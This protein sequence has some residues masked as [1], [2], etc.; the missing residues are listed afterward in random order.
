[1]IKAHTDY[2]KELTDTFFQPLLKDLSIENLGESQRGKTTDVLIRW[3]QENYMVEVEDEEKSSVELSLPKNVDTLE[4]GILHAV[5]TSISV[6]FEGLTSMQGLIQGLLMKLYDIIHYHRSIISEFDDFELVYPFLPIENPNITKYSDK[7]ELTSD[8]D[9]MF[10]PFLFRFTAISNKNLK[11]AYKFPAEYKNK[12]NS[13]IYQIIFQSLGTLFGDI[14][15]IK[16]YANKNEFLRTKKS[17]FMEIVEKVEK[18]ATNKKESLVSFI[19][20]LGQMMRTTGE[21]KLE[22]NVI[23]RKKRIIAELESFYT[24]DTKPIS[25]F[26]IMDALASS[27]DMTFSLRYFL[28]GPD[29]DGED[30][31]IYDPSWKVESFKGIDDWEDVFTGNKNHKALWSYLTKGEKSIITDNKG[32]RHILLNNLLGNIMGKDLGR[33]T[34]TFSE[35]IKRADSYDLTDNKLKL[36]SKPFILSLYE[37][38]LEL[39]AKLLMNHILNGFKIHGLRFKKVKGESPV[40]T[41]QGISNSILKFV[42]LEV[43]D[44]GSLRK[45]VNEKVVPFGRRIES[46]IGKAK[47]AFTGKDLL[48]DDSM[49]KVMFQLNKQTEDLKQ[50]NLFDLMFYHPFYNALAT[51]EKVK[52]FN[53]DVE[54]GT[55]KIID[56]IIDGVNVMNESVSTLKKDGMKSNSLAKPMAELFTQFGSS[57]DATSKEVHPLRELID[58]FGIFIIP[59]TEW[60]N[61]DKS[62]LNDFTDEMVKITTI[63]NNIELA[64]RVNK[65]TKKIA[66][67]DD[68]SVHLAIKQVYTLINEL[69]RD[70][71]EKK[72]T[73]EGFNDFKKLV[74]KDIQVFNKKKKKGVEDYQAILRY[75]DFIVGLKTVKI[76][77]KDEPRIVIT[78]KIGNGD[79]FTIGDGIEIVV[80]TSTKPRKTTGNENDTQILSKT[81]INRLEQYEKDKDTKSYNRFQDELYRTLIVATGTI[82]TEDLLNQF[83]GTDIV[84]YQKLLKVYRMDLLLQRSRDEVN[85]GDL[86]VGVENIIFEFINGKLSVDSVNGIT[87]SNAKQLY[88]FLKKYFGIGELLYEKGDIVYFIDRDGK[89]ENINGMFSITGDSIQPDKDTVKLHKKIDPSKEVI[90]RSKVSFMRIVSEETMEEANAA[91]KYTVY[92]LLLADESRI[93]EKALLCLKKLSESR[94]KIKADKRVKHY[95]DF[96]KTLIET[97]GKSDKFVVRNLSGL[98]AEITLKAS[99]DIKEDIEVISDKVDRRNF[100][101]TLYVII[102]KLLSKMMKIDLTGIKLENGRTVVNEPLFYRKGDIVKLIDLKSGLLNDTTVTSFTSITKDERSLNVRIANKKTAPPETII[103]NQTVEE[104]NS[105]ITVEDIIMLMKKIR[106]SSN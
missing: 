7:E 13:E 49:D 81:I 89:Q 57:I 69:N 14:E 3:V 104:L 27:R 99:D 78:S 95:I 36:A 106:G 37:R 67:D 71:Q 8:E 68:K 60:Y 87:N 6:T 96:Y 20:M 79:P 51:A 92:K 63:K 22:F 18:D 83:I 84:E 33:G 42:D 72:K 86:P 28:F 11:G 75:I 25:K 94:K 62:I 50:L 73:E 32:F 24:G 85:D 12:K 40:D 53:K 5:L 17:P 103:D 45:Y 97:Y 66:N 74:Q 54:K 52:E 64:K 19:L 46:D 2:L 100:I 56:Q 30:T 26:V 93:T 10:N 59:E 4:L 38:R 29:K 105:G 9:G 80:D 55:K 102:K 48:L 16:L 70:V 82:L 23:T 88:I 76:N 98:L 15:L 44:I 91:T 77:D 47:E 21:T 58:E 65:L 61:E 43:L 41:L 90:D 31:F 39:D 34:L 101:N 35:F 1:M